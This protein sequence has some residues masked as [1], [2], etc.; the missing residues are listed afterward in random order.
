M[1][2][3]VY[4]QYGPPEVV[5]LTD[6]DK[7]LPSAMEILVKVRATTVAAG[8]WRMRKADPFFTRLYNGLYRPKRVNILGFELAG[9]VEATGSEV[10]RFK[11]GDSVF[12]FTG[13][14]FGA[15]AQYRCL[16]ERGKILKVGLVAHKPLNM[17]FEQAAAVPIGGLTAQGLLRRAGVQSGERVLVYGASGSVGTFAVQLARHLARRSLAYAA[18]EPGIIR[19]LGADDVI[20][21]TQDD[22]VRR[23][24]VFDV[25]FDAVA[26]CSVARCKAVLKK[27]GRFISVRGSPK[28]REGDLESLKVLIEANKVTAVIDRLY[29][30]E[31]IADAH[32]YVEEG[33]KRGNVVVTIPHTN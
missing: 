19:S 7:P 22:F 16:A 9:E 21:Y 11:A 29:P 26:K 33:H 32:R 13:I 20:D 5:H 4:K 12:A 8:D 3:A 23:G 28:L 24:R 6:V 1:K 17:S 27:G 10:R 30:L 18:R 31:Q 2:A 15:H 25:V 14:G